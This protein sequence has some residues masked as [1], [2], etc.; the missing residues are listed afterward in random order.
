MLRCLCC[1][2]E[3]INPKEDE[4]KTCWHEKCIKKFFGTEKLPELDLSN[5]ELEKLVNGSVNKKLTVPGVQKKISLH[6][7]S[8]EHSVRLT[9]VD[10]PTG[11][12]LKPQSDDFAFLPE[13]EFLLMKMADIA[14]IKVVPN[15]LVFLDG[16]YAYIT[17]RIDR[18]EGRLYAMED[19][20]QL[21]G[22]MTADKYRSSYESCG[23]VI[24][25][26]SKNIGLDMTEFY[27]RLL[28]CFLTGNSDMHLKN[29]S[30][31]EEGPG[32]R[33]YSLSAAYD[34]LPVN[35]IM[36]EDKEQMALTLNGKKSNLKKNDFIA[37][38]SNLE[39]REKVAYGMIKQML[40]YK[41]IFKDVIDISYVSDEM[42]ERLKDIIDVRAE[43]L[44]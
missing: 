10:Y 37:L 16:K 29:F 26:Y 7:Q 25:K 20:C 40:K 22:R 18:Y 38:A 35:V 13:S 2:K 11:Y 31:I 33:I 43:V 6:L 36:P 39:I 30:L 3:M 34:M 12:I 23:K 5:Q 41:K 9:I 4:V 19:F 14:G 8:E 24:R 42:K 28:F 17:K 44:S 21:S 1:N 15:A 27:Y 32:N